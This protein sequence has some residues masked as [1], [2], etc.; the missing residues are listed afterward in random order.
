MSVGDHTIWIET[1]PQAFLAALIEG[2]APTNIRI[3][4]RECLEQIHIDFAS[5]LASIPWG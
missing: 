5:E 2:E 1:S 3:E 4:L